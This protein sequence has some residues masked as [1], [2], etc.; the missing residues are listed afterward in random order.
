MLTLE[1]LD[2]ATQKDAIIA[3]LL[4]QRFY[5][6]QTDGMYS[7]NEIVHI[8]DHTTPE[9]CK[10]YDRAYGAIEDCNDGLGY[11]WLVSDEDDSF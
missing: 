4:L 5:G 7:R 3:R 11:L 1:K 6:V 10:F 8:L 2:I 9:D